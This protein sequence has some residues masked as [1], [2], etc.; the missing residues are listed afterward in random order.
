MKTKL[1]EEI[2]LS[3]NLADKIKVRDDEILRLHD[4]Y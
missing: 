1:E 3:K 4:L 2:H